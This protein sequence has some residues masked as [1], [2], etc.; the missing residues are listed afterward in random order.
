MLFQQ[1][2]FTETREKQSNNN[3]EKQNKEWLKS[4][5]NPDQSQWRE[6]CSEIHYYFRNNI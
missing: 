4:I 5:D 6:Q 3:S 2:F 1:I